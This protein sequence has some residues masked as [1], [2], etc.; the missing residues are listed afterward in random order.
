MTPAVTWYSQIAVNGWSRIERWR[1]RLRDLDRIMASLTKSLLL[2]QS[3]TEKL[4]V[5]ADLAE[6]TQHRKCLTDRIGRE[7]MRMMTFSCAWSCRDHELHCPRPL[8]S[9]QEGTQ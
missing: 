4:H 8:Q 1:A 3:L 9:H 6:L 7:W 5:A 2:P